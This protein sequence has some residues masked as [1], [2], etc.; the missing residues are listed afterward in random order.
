MNILKKLLKP[1]RPILHKNN[2]PNFKKVA[3]FVIWFIKH[4]R[5]VNAITNESNNVIFNEGY[6]PA[7]GTKNNPE[8]AKHD[9]NNLVEWFTIKLFTDLNMLK[10]VAQE[11]FKQFIDM[12]NEVSVKKLLILM[13]LEKKYDI[14]NENFDYNKEIEKIP[15]GDD[16][17][18]FKLYKLIDNV[19]AAETRILV[20]VYHSF[21][22]KWYVFREDKYEDMLQNGSDL[23]KKIFFI[24]QSGLDFLNE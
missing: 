11:E 22:N 8:S 13:E 14:N 12:E 3:T 18:F 4:E 17:E 5:V 7:S 1:K 15:V 24:I 16:R 19:S 10:D 21:F 9:I 6:R 20:W 2:I 23:E